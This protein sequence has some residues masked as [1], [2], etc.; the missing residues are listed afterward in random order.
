MDDKKQDQTR[1][2]A[3]TAHAIGTDQDEAAFRAKLAVIARHTPKNELRPA[4]KEP[5]RRPD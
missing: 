5:K 4:P 3:E 2:F 1:R